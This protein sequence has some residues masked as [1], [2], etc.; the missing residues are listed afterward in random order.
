MYN[1]VCREVLVHLLGTAAKQRTTYCSQGVA[2][3]QPI[4]PPCD[5][6]AAVKS[7]LVALCFLTL[8]SLSL[9]SLELCEWRGQN[10]RT[11]TVGWFPA[12]LTAP[13]FPPGVVA[14]AAIVSTS[15]PN[16]PPSSA[17]ISAPVKGSLQHTGHGDIKPDRCWGTPESLE[18]SVTSFLSVLLM[19]K[20]Q[21]NMINLTKPHI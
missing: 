9:C 10:Q 18:E 5:H 15:P 19:V 17:L 4:T 20:Y 1:V 14:T 2:T 21:G 13:S 8:P 16:P 3:W 12:S 6:Y 11:L 7:K